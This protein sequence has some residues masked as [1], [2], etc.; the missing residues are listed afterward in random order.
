MLAVM[1]SVWVRRTGFAIGIF[2]SIWAQKTSF[3]QLLDVWSRKIK[4]DSGIDL[5]AMGD[6]LPM[7]ASDGLLTFPDNPLKAIT[8]SVLPTDYTWLV[9]T[10]AVAYL[11]FFIWFSRKLYLDKDPDLFRCKIGDGRFNIGEPEHKT[12]SFYFVCT[13]RCALQHFNALFTE[14]ELFSINDGTR[15]GRNMFFLV[16]RARVITR[17][18]LLTG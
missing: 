6:Y 3:P 7:N 14:D 18:R 4:I 2:S 9:V 13:H 11:A 10:L 12:G 1:I 16:A 17:L 15:N 5:G 8:K